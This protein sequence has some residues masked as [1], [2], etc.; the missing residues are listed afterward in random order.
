MASN[1]NNL[2]ADESELCELT[3]KEL[4]PILIEHAI[5]G[6]A[7]GIEGAPG[8][9][10]SDIVK[11]AAML[12]GKPMLPPMNLE[13]SDST[14]MKGLPAFSDDKLTHHWAKDKRWLH[15]TAFTNFMDELPRGSIPAQGA[16]CMALLENRIDDLYLPDGT[17]HVWA[18][19]RTQDRAGANR[20]PSIVYQR[21]SMYGLRY[22][23][24]SQIEYMLDLPEE[25]VDLL[26][27]RFLRMKGDGAM[28]FDPAKKIN[29]TPR[30][31]TWVSRYIA[32]THQ[33]DPAAASATAQQAAPRPLH[34]A[35]IAGKIGKGMATELMAFRELAPQL[36]P[37]EQII[38]APDSAKVP[39][40]VSAL[41]LVTDSMADKAGLGTFDAM[42]TYAKRLPPEFQAAFVNSAV[43]RHSEVTAT[44]GFISWGLSFTSNL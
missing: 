27:L 4:L 18:G 37:I 12:A 8:G 31:W 15:P 44:R 24:Q 40:N 36:P 17:W 42:V 3:P 9:G 22:D 1:P 38:M 35:T 41:F 33:P 6:E 7:V 39:D 20:V 23:A 13:L 16:A 11:Q 43:K 30:S 25:E 19:N 10:K 29:A 26:T 14:D 28:S 5:A 21:C 2:L 34:Y 32:S